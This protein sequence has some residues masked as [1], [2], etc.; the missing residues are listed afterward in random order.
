MISLSYL[1]QLT[2]V[3]KL[4]AGIFTVAVAIIALSLNVYF[5][6]DSTEMADKAASVYDFSYVDIDGKEQSMGRYKGR[7]L[8]VVNVASKC[9]YT[10]ANYE[11]LQSLYEKYN[12]KGLSVLG[13]PCDQFMSQEPGTES[14]IKEF[15]CSRYKVT[16]DMAKKIDVNGANAHPLWEFLKKKKGG[17]LGNFIKWNFTKF[18]IDKNGEVLARHGPS[19]NPNDFEADLV[20]LLNQ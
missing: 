1:R 3:S 15:A 9:G 2:T 12:E 4:S 6:S 11:Q 14:E 8:I 18:V 17:T 16:F 13:F 20:K 5:T 7:V 10:K 19:T